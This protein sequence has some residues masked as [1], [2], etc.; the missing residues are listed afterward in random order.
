MLFAGQEGKSWQVKVGSVERTP[1]MQG[2]ERT[3]VL[4]LFLL[5][6]G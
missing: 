4:L 3:C 5:L 2:E 6:L 1:S